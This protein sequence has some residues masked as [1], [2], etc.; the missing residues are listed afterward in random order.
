MTLIARIAS[1]LDSAG[2]SWAVIGA[3]AIAAHGI[4]RST[5]DMD[6]LVDDSRVLDPTMWKPLEPATSVDVRRG[7]HDDPL[8]GVA[9][10]RA[11][12]ERP[13]DL[14]VGR[15]RWLGGVLRRAADIDLEWGTLR[16][17]QRSDLILLKLYAGGSQDRWDIEQLLDDDSRPLLIAEVEQRL[18][19][20]PARSQDLW[21]TILTGSGA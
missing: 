20:L 12:G 2:L 7:D 6:V 8:A 17:V 5:L 11:P 19:D 3:S 4:S 10:F 1:I 15:G 16:V 9:R 13:V 21:Q 14:V 18:S